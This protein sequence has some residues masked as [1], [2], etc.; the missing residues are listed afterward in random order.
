MLRISR[1]THTEDCK[2]LMA[3]PSLRGVISCALD[4]SQ[5]RRSPIYR[6][7]PRPLFSRGLHFFA[8]LQRAHFQRARELA[9]ASAPPGSEYADTFGGDASGST[10]QTRRSLK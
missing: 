3:L 7:S 1:G 9:A 4:F 5:E 6:F 2:N 10:N 8:V